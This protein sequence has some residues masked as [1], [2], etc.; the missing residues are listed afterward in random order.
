M[1]LHLGCGRNHLKGY[2]NCDISPS[3][4]PD[5]IVDLEKKLPFKDGEVSEIIAEHV[6][7]HIDNFVPLMHELWRICQNHSIIKIKV[8]FYS[9]WGQFNDPTHVRFFTPF[10][11]DYFQL[12]NYSHEVN[13]KTKMFHVLKRKIN[14]GVGKSKV[15]NGFFNPLINFNKKM[16]CRFFAWIFPAAEIEFELKVIK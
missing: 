5:K 3:V 9:S 13:A 10:T 16:Y 6:L 1:R 7:E 15:L 2:V 4:N 12:G 11:F 14:F 8:P